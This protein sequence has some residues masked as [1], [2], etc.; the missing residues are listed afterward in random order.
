MGNILTGNGLEVSKYFGPRY[1]LGSVRKDHR[2]FGANLVARRAAAE[3]QSNELAKAVHVKPPTMSKWE[4]ARRPP[5]TRTLLKLA[6]ALN[7]S[8]DDL[9]LGVDPAY[10]R[11]IATRDLIR[12]STD[13]PSGFPTRTGDH[14]E[15]A[16]ARVFELEREN[17]ALKIALDKVQDVASDLLQIA[18]VGAASRRAAAQ[19]SR[20]GG[21]DRKTG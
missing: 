9:L 19:R 1:L 4:S 14:D 5:A 18:K 6:T 12:Q 8:I 11:V 21:G 17:E 13:Q 10:D 2:G 3:M 15:P 20:R 7:C 16:A